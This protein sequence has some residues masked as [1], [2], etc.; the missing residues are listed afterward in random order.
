MTVEPQAAVEPQARPTAAG[1][2]HLGDHEY[3]E[4]PEPGTECDGWA[5]LLAAYIDSLTLTPGGDEGH[6]GG[7]G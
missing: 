3:L 7:C 2:D 5:N 1:R 6:A 4:L